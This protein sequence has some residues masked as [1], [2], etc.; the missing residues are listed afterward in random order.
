M[1]DQYLYVKNK[2]RRR[3]F[4][5][6]AHAGYTNEVIS[7]QEGVHTIH[8]DDALHNTQEV[9]VA[10]TTPQSPHVLSFALQGDDDTE[11]Y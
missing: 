6:G 11:D 8:L 2:K 7:I 9:F 3:V 1:M 4:V 5:D 10:Q